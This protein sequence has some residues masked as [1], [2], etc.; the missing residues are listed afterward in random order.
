MHGATLTI[1]LYTI[2]IY[3][4]TIKHVT[5]LFHELL[6]RQACLSKEGCSLFFVIPTI[7]VSSFL[8]NSCFLNIHT[9]LVFAFLLDK[10]SFFFFCKS[11]II[12]FTQDR[13][14]VSY[15]PLNLFT[16]FGL[17]VYCGYMYLNFL[18]WQAWLNKS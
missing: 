17:L 5:I 7:P 11:P 13:Y 10:L 14:W 3:Q 12:F 9:Y 15:I 6:S 18:V 2:P 16:I 4:L 8:T 1:N